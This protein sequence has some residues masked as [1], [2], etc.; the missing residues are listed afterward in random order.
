MKSY[1]TQIEIEDSA[2]DHIATVKT[3]D[4]ASA[5]VTLKGGL[6][7]PKSWLEFSDAVTNAIKQLELDA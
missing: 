2:K 3:F 7:T 4:E 1:I 6:F 5:E